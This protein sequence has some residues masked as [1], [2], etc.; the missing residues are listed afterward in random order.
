MPNYLLAVHTS[1]DTETAQPSE[2]QPEPTP[3]DMRARMA[4]MLE[5]EADIDAAGAWVFSG[6]LTD[7]GSATVVRDDGGTMS[8]TD[9]PYA[10]SKEHIA[11]F[12]VIEAADLD[13]ALGWAERVTRC[14][15]RP[16]EVRAFAATGRIP[17]PEAEQAG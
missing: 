17:S 16:I 10:E 4:D 3:D 6:G 11:G 12:Y 5:L 15:G 9:G 7:P 14:V 2:P 1:S 8:M 13:A